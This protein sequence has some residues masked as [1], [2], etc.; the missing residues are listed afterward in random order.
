MCFS[1][2]YHSKYPKSITP[3]LLVSIFYQLTSKKNQVLAGNL[4]HGRQTLQLI[5]F[6]LIKNMRYWRKLVST[7][8]VSLLKYSVILLFIT[9]LSWQFPLFHF[10]LLI[11]LFAFQTILTTAADKSEEHTESQCTL[12][13]DN[14][15]KVI[16][17]FTHVEYCLN[18]YDCGKCN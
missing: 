2:L 3:Y 4:T 1:C 6:Y 17:C 9:W 16:V 13:K 14:Q 15:S 10:P 12:N 5:K 7:I 8:K 18:I 11:C